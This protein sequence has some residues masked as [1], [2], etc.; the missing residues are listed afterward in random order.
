MDEYVTIKI[1]SELAELIDKVIESKRYGYRSRA[2][3]V[4]EAIREKLRQL[5]YIK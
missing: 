3:F 2:E 4:N 5:G 1:P